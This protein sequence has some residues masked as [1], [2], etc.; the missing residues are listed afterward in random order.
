MICQ[1]Q[2]I[3]NQRIAG[4]LSKPAPAIM[5]GMVLLNKAWV[6]PQSRVRKGKAAYMQ[7]V[8]ENGCNKSEACLAPQAGHIRVHAPEITV[9]RADVPD[10]PS[11][12]GRG[13]PKKLAE[14]KIVEPPTVL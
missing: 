2:R 11:K 6:R 3:R 1:S 7:R 9:E 4:A 14:A 5:L 8:Q 10:E 12:K 13:R